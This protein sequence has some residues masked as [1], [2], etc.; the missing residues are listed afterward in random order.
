MLIQTNRSLYT[1]AILVSIGFGNIYSC[2]SDDTLEDDKRTTKAPSAENPT[3][4]WAFKDINNANLTRLICA[5][6]NLPDLKEREQYV[7]LIRS[8][9]FCKSLIQNNQDT[10]SQVVAEFA[11]ESICTEGREI[12]L[13]TLD[14]LH[15]NKLIN[16]NDDMEIIQELSAVFC[17]FHE[18]KEMQ[19]KIVM[20]MNSPFFQGSI[21]KQKLTVLRGLFGYNTESTEPSLCPKMDPTPRTK[22]KAS[23]FAEAMSNPVPRRIS[24]FD[25]YFKTHK[26]FVDA[27]IEK[28]SI[29]A[30]YLERM[31]VPESDIATRIELFKQISYSSK[32]ELESAMDTINRLLKR[33]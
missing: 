18:N 26:Y 19:E 31:I 15:T 5:F 25:H 28:L 10:L 22:Y 2:S 3:D 33:F 12:L 4:A 21:S 29:H 13:S 20:A 14:F 6:K 30:N 16:E 9:T 11:Y 17:C 32:E 27:V 23:T 8:S 7:E 1:L 24:Y